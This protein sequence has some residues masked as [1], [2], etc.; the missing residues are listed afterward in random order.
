M[1]LINLCD[2]KGATDDYSKRPYLLRAWESTE[3]H[4]KALELARTAECCVFAGTDALPYE[5][6]RMKFGLMMLILQLRNCAIAFRNANVI[7]L[8]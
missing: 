1:E 5:K 7:S 4:E 6:E 8:I 2:T 3:A